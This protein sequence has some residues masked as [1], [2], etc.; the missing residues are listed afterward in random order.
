M[1]E[2]PGFSLGS[3]IVLEYSSTFNSVLIESYVGFEDMPTAAAYKVRIVLMMEIPGFSLG[4]HLLF[5]L[6]SGA[7][8]RCPFVY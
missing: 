2:S 7:L 1:M 3:P 4:T 5:F 6:S 8:E